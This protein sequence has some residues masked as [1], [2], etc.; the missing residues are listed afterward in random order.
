[1]SKSH[2]LKIALVLVSPQAGSL[3]GLYWM[4]E[5]CHTMTLKKMPGRVVREA[6]K[7]PFVKSK[8]GIIHSALFHRTEQLYS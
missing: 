2:A 8:V 4:V 3:A 6:L 7:Y 5:F 1:M